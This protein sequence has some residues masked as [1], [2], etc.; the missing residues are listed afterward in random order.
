MSVLC[1]RGNFENVWSLCHL[2]CCLPSLSGSFPSSSPHSFASAGS[3]CMLSVSPLPTFDAFYSTFVSKSHHNNHALFPVPTPTFVCVQ[4]SMTQAVMQ[5]DSQFVCDKQSNFSHFMEAI[6]FTANK[7]SFSAINYFCSWSAALCR[8][9]TWC[10]FLYISLAYLFFYGGQICHSNETFCS[11][12][13]GVLGNTSAFLAVSAW[14]MRVMSTKL[15]WWRHQT[16]VE[17]LLERNNLTS[18]TTISFHA[19]ST[20]L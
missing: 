4:H 2:P 18:T 5:F 11:S 9:A 16:G 19:C 10:N 20:Q 8:C 1:L 3:P 14:Y 13:E 7:H 15:S 12:S 17:S 6:W